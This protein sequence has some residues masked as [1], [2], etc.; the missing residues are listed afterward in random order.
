MYYKGGKTYLKTGDVLSLTGLTAGQ[1]NGAR[2]RGDINPIQF[3]ERGD[4]CYEPTEILA[5]HRQISSSKKLGSTK[6][7]K[8]PAIRDRMEYQRIVNILRRMG[9]EVEDIAGLKSNEDGTYSVDYQPHL[10]TETSNTALGS[11]LKN[12]GPTTGVHDS[13]PFRFHLGSDEL[14]T[15]PEAFEDF[16][17]IV[18]PNEEGSCF[19]YYD[20]TNS[21]CGGNCNFSASCAALRFRVLLVIGE[22]LDNGLDRQEIITQELDLVEREIERT[23]KRLAYLEEA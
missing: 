7:R 2:N 22:G 15:Y 23:R 10:L 20:E 12:D 4:Y 6:L 17:N 19:G 8:V 5:A 16:E 14:P 18:D 9:L 1:L 13:L 21:E 11:L 3:V